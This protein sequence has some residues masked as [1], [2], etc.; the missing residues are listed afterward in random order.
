MRYNTGNPVEPSGSSDPRDLHDNAG[1]IDLSA[2][3][4]AP[5]W[6][7]RLGRTRRSLAGID[8]QFDSSQASRELEF[9]EFLLS[10]GYVDIGDY[11]PGLLIDARNEIFRKDGEY[12][13]ISP[14][15]EIPYITTG[16]WGDEQSSFTSIGDAALRQQLA[17]PSGAGLVSFRQAAVGAA[18][19]SILSRM[20]DQVFVSDFVGAVGDGIADDT[21]AFVLAANTG[22]SVFVP[23]GDWQVN[24]TT[25]EQAAAIKDLLSRATVDGALTI[26]FGPREFEFSTPLVYRVEGGQRVRIRGAAPITTSITGQVSVTGSA[27]AWDVVLSLGSV[28][29]ISTGDWLDTATTGGSGDHY[30]HRGAWRI[31]A[32]DTANSRVTVRNTHRQSAFPANGI[33]F[34]ISVVKR[35]T[36]LF[37]NCDG[38]VVPA[39]IIGEVSSLVVAGNS[40][41][42]WSSA[43]VTGT[44]K[45]THGFVIGSQTIASNGKS[46]NANPFGVSGGHVSGPY[47]SVAGFDQQGIVCEGGGTFWGDFAA[48]CSNKRRGFYAST[49]SAI[50]AKHISA[51][52]NYLDGVIADL[53]GSVYSSSNSCASGNGGSG[54]SS[55]QSCMLSFDTGFMTGNRSHGA[56]IVESAAAQ[57]VNSVIMGNGNSGVLAAYNSTVYCD[58]SQILNNTGYGVDANFNSSVRAPSITASGNTQYGLRSTEKSFI[59]HTGANLAGNTLGPFTFRADGMMLDGSTCRQGPAFN[60]EYRAQNPTTLC[61]VRITSTSGGDDLQIG[62]DTS[63]SGSYT[64]KFHFR[65]GTT[66]L[67]SETDNDTPNGR[68][69][70]RWSVLFS[71]TGTI[72]TSDAR[73]K[74]PIQP[75]TEGHLRAGVRIADELGLFQWNDRVEKYG[76]NVARLHSGQTVQRVIEIFTE[77]GVD[78]MRLAA[79]CYDKWDAY[80]E[81]ISAAIYEGD[82]LIAEEVV[83][84]HEAGDRYSLRDHQLQYLLTA[85]L[86]W[87]QREIMARLDALESK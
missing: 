27:G 17:S 11:A 67:Y 9:Q 81:V 72:N 65:S 59:N 38:F 43:N 45:G 56:N 20:R 7:D 31:T 3:G 29:G 4:E 49:G 76:E 14:S 21:A 85:S 19:R 61:G 74:T 78:P 41:E 50:R 66:G 80:D 70:N 12:Y 16:V 77:E 46:D 32:V 8:Q 44:E 37:K 34:S 86:A 10:A 2:N 87:R 71:G 5:T 82:K 60:S 75:F 15:V 36:L 79:V 28:D 54:V 63:G 68:A 39:S 1:N 83:L 62:H 64:P 13:R 42:Y 48:S 69:Q 57:F 6:I 23:D 53:A 73:L 84:H 33:N 30:A 35:T 40:D 26:N 47:L 22:R 24:I 18:V 25:D 52:G 55:S 58:G 51:C